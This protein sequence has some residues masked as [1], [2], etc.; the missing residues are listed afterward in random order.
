MALNPNFN[1]IGQAFIQQVRSDHNDMSRFY[2]DIS[3]W[4]S[5]ELFNHDTHDY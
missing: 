5:I 4:K 1:Q 3:W 2:P